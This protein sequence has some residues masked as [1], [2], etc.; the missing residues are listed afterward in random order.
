MV[1]KRNKMKLTF[2]SA[3]FVAVISPTFCQPFF[4][5]DINGLVDNLHKKFNQLGDATK[6]KLNDLKNSLE[7]VSFKGM[8]EKARTEM[9]EKYNQLYDATSELTQEDAEKMIKEIKQKVENW[10]K[11]I[12]ELKTDF[13]NKIEEI[14]INKTEIEKYWVKIE[15]NFSFL[16][17]EDRANL[18]SALNELKK[19][20]LTPTDRE[21][22]LKVVRTLS[23]KVQV[24]NMFD[25]ITDKVERC[26]AIAKEIA[27]TDAKTDGQKYDELEKIL[28][29]EGCIPPIPMWATILIVFVVLI[30][31]LVCIG[32]LVKKMC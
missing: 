25:D 30:L 6:S 20:N 5:D 3:I 14:K 29:D 2:I 32:V 24:S 18:E 8:S 12:G 17:E 16:S 10:K 4:G 9:E 22:H 21:K 11:K 28:K 31:L 15:E 1:S 27:D 26:T 23:T 7:D 19:D 13:K